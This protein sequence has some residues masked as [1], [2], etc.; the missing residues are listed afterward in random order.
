MDV[1]VVDRR[2]VT[3]EEQVVDDRN[4]GSEQDRA[5]PGYGADQHRNDGEY[6]QIH[7]ALVAYRAIR[8]PKAVVRE[9][10]RAVQ[11]P[12]LQYQRNHF[13]TRRK[14]RSVSCGRPE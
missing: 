12:S 3:Q 13:S 11:N 7:G 4:Q 2:E 9:K 5:D 1:G 14:K 10:C 8:L 6:E